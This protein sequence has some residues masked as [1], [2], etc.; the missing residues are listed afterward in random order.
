MVKGYLGVFISS[1]V[2]SSRSP[3][4]FNPA[5]TWKFYFYFIWKLL[6][7][8][9]LLKISARFNK[10]IHTAHNRQSD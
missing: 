1:T 2:S 9:E 4:A 6:D 5:K 8:Y 7:D 10:K 3:V